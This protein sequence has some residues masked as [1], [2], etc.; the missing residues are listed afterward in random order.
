M[1][2]LEAFLLGS[3]LTGAWRKSDVLSCT[4]NNFIVEGFAMTAQ[5]LIVSLGTWCL[6]RIEAKPPSMRANLNFLTRSGDLTRFVFFQVVV[7]P[8]A[9]HIPAVVG[10]IKSDIAV[11]A[12]N[13]NFKV[14]V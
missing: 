4:I 1:D 11:S 10:S 3:H 13:C 2:I 8:V 5:Q 6:E 14:S 12:Q 7:A 9:L